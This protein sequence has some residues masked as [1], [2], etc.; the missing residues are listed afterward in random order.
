MARTPTEGEL[1]SLRRHFEI[2]RE[3]A[4]RLRR[5]PKERR[6]RLYAEVYAE[7]FRRVE[8]PG[9]AEAQRAQVGLLLELLEPLLA[10]ARTFLEIG[11]GSCE[12]SLALA[13][14]LDVDRDDRV[15]VLPGDGAIVAAVLGVAPAARDVGAALGADVDGLGRFTHG[16]SLSRKS[17]RDV[18]SLGPLG[19]AGWVIV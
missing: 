13:G 9:N 1:E 15:A 17:H 12:L 18:G 8:M 11:A 6:K 3:L 14:R 5:A 4:D 7:L 10:G 19:Q 2:E 16:L